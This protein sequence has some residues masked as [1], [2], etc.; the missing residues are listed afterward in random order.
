MFKAKL[1]QLGEER[2]QQEVTGWRHGSDRGNGYKCEHHGGGQGQWAE[3]DG[4]LG[5]VARGRARRKSLPVFQTRSLREQ[6]ECSCALGWGRQVDEEWQWALLYTRF[7]SILGPS[8][9]EKKWV[10][11]LS[12]SPTDHFYHPQPP[13]PTCLLPDFWPQPSCASIMLPL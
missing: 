10:L 8:K 11:V 12:W 6:R 2:A 5:V 9:G 1:V 7:E 13:Y 4:R 3:Q